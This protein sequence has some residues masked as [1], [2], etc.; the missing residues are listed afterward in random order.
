MT[1]T[2]LVVLTFNVNSKKYGVLK[3]RVGWRNRRAEVVVF[4]VPF[5]ASEA[6]RDAV[7]LAGRLGDRVEAREVRVKERALSLLN[8]AINSASEQEL[9][10]R[11]WP[12]ELSYWHGN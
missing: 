12:L 8:E 6:A 1:D 7:R 10:L 3:R 11:L 5:Q 2:V 9:L 4:D